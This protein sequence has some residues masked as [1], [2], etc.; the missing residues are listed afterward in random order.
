MSTLNSSVRNFRFSGA[1][2]GYRDENDRDLTEVD[3]EQKVRLISNYFQIDLA[4]VKKI[5]CYTLTFTYKSGRD[6]Y[7]TLKSK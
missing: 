3:P 5:Y 1:D 4:K 6:V 2:A 7:E